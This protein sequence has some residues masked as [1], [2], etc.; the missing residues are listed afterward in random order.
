MSS[1]DMQTH[2]TCS[3]SAASQ[4]RGKALSLST[5]A[6]DSHSGHGDSDGGRGCSLRQ[7]SSS[8]HVL[9]DEDVAVEPI[10]SDVQAPTT[11]ID[12]SA[13]SYTLSSPTKD[14]LDGVQPGEWFRS[15]KSDEARALSISVNSSQA[16]FGG[17]PPE[18][19]TQ[20]E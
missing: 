17:E 19:D 8:S 7:R 6:T 13:G 16:P 5:T 2:Q 14:R 12:S 9:G 1:P 15:P 3:S 4:Q 18:G 11:P 20:D 10:G